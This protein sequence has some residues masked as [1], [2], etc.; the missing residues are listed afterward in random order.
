MVRNVG[1]PQEAVAPALF[2]VAEIRRPWASVFAFPTIAGRLASD[3]VTHLICRS[4]EVEKCM[5]DLNRLVATPAALIRAR[6]LL[7]ELADQK[8][9]ELRHLIR[10]EIE[11]VL[12][13]DRTTLLR[14][15]EIMLEQRA[16][17]E[18]LEQRLAC[19]LEPDISSLRTRRTSRMLYRLQRFDVAL[20]QWDATGFRATAS[21]LGSHRIGSSEPARFHLSLRQYEVIRQPK[22]ALEYQV[23]TGLPL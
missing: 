12:P 16:A 13:S 6:S 15:V 18:S 2:S 11:S 14:D 10:L 9:N 17:M 3:E 7:R 19:L 21:D 4:D 5:E 22:A 23:K 8:R 20:G 1:T